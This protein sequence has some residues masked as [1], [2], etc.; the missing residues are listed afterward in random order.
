MIYLRKF[1]ESED[2]DQNLSNLRE[3]L[4]EVSDR[5]GDLEKTFITAV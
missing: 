5:L 3:S 4:L 2:N 1:N